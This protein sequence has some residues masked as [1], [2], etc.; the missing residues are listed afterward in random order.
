MDAYPALASVDF[1]LSALQ[2]GAW[3]AKRD[4]WTAIAA[5]FAS[6]SPPALPAASTSLAALAAATAAK[7]K[8]A[9][10]LKA[11]FSAVRVCAD[12]ATAEQAFSR[13]A[14]SAFA[15]SG[16]SALTDKKLVAVRSLLHCPP[17]PPH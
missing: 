5:A 7:E 1:D 17:H 8:N 16:T 15:A 10:V 9:N 12:T 14:A 4:A 13:S 3:S 11:M 2:S 6:D